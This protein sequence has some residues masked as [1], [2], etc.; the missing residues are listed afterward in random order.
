[1]V[2][3]LKTVTAIV[4]ISKTN[5]ATATGEA[6]DTL[7]FRY[8]AIHVF[9]STADVVSNKPSVL[10]VQESATTDASNFADI[11]GAVGGT[12]F[13]VANSL[14]SLPNN[15]QFG[16]NIGPARKRYLRVLVSPATTQVIAGSAIL[17]RGEEAPTTAAKA[18]VLNLVTL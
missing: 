12:D 6:I 7:G 4:P 15:Y 10:K 13:T 5:A 16:I 11:S 18:G 8:C 3:Q 9:A 14:T 17:T 2:P 1:M